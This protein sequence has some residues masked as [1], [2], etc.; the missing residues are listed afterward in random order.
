MH[1]YIHWILLNVLFV[2][3]RASQFSKISGG[4]PQATFLSKRYKNNC[5]LATRSAK[6]PFFQTCNPLKKFW[7]WVWIVHVT[8]GNYVYNH[9]CV[10]LFCSCQMGIAING[11]IYFHVQ[12]SAASTLEAVSDYILCCLCCH[13]QPWEPI[14]NLPALTVI[15]TLQFVS[16]VRTVI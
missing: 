6:S 12:P 14:L 16:D 10:I 5:C 15:T 8:I 11:N 3:L 7:L 2:C 1:Q 4:G 13:W 9:F